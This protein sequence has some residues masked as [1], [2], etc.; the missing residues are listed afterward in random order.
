MWQTFKHKPV[1]DIEQRILTDIATA[2][3]RNLTFYIG[4]D[5]QFKKGKIKFI[6]A[7]VI[8]FD[9]NGGRGYYQ[10]QSEKISYKISIRQK[11]IRETQMSLEVAA[12]L[13]PLLESLNVGYCIEEIHADINKDPMHKSHAMMKE[14]MGWIEAMGY[15]PRVKPEGWVAMEVA[16]KY[17]K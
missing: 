10:T 12:W 5:S 14:V 2:P 8:L 9:G 3:T 11:I 6:T 7:V 15:T 4:S 13:N 16:D 1:T 17:T